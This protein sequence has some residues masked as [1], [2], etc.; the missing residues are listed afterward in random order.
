MR[1]ADRFGDNGTIG[2]VICKPGA[3]GEWEIDTWLM[4]CRVLG[5]RVEHAVLQELL[6]LARARGVERLIG[7]YAP[8]ARNGLVRDHY[9]QLGFAPLGEDASGVSRWV[10]ETSAALGGPALPFRRAG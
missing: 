8:T 10:I 1:L 5:R 9:A 6:A 7:T 3:P 4:S 2:A